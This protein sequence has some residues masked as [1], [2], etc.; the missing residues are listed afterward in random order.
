LSIGRDRTNA[1]HVGGRW[2]K[3][4]TTTVC[5]CEMIEDEKE[6]EMDGDKLGV[7][8]KALGS[9]AKTAR[10]GKVVC[11]VLR[12]RDKGYLLNLTRRSEAG[13]CRQDAG[14]DGKKQT[15]DVPAPQDGAERRMENN[16]DASSQADAAVTERRRRRRRCPQRLLRSPGI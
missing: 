7:F 8:C 4:A 13:S 9:A 11:F 2:A 1:D 10:Q 14:Q 6:V 15:N 12:C 5:R 16:L 3:R